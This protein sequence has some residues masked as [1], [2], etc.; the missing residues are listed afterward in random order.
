M[1]IQDEINRINQNIANTYSAMGEM[2]ATLPANQNSD[3]LANTVRSVPQGGTSGGENKI[4]RVAA[5]AI[6]TSQ[7]GGNMTVENCSFA[8]IREA[9]D[10]GYYIY[11]DGD[12]SDLGINGFVT[13]PMSIIDF[14]NK[15]ISFTRA[16][17]ISGEPTYLGIYIFESENLNNFIIRPLTSS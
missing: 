3:N 13:I 17:D 5:T 8:Q 7:T 1:S 10:N 9:Y 2:G 14:T 11:V 4:F 16:I 12:L 15:Y 6:P